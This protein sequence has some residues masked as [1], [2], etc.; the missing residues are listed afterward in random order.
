MTRDLKFNVKKER[1][2]DI[3]ETVLDYYKG[4]NLSNYA[5][6]KNIRRIQKKITQRALEILNI[7]DKNSL[8]LDAG[9]GP[10]FSSTY[11]HELGYKVI[12]LDIIAD[13]LK[14]YNLS[15]FNPIIADM[16]K[17]PF[18]TNVID[19]VISISALQ[20]IYRNPQNRRERKNMETLFK[21]LYPILKRNGRAIFQFYPKNNYIMEKI[22]EI[23]IT[24]TNFNGGFIIDNPNNPRKRKVYLFLEKKKY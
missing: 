8:I 20:W 2:E 4:D 12:A 10:G 9:C 5:R 22:K 24:N 18:R 19:A 13:F 7:E 1:P 16:C 23:I 14:Y 21:T 15:D 3:Y 11:L 17:L 6:S